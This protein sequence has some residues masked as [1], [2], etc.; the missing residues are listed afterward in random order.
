M[1][2]MPPKSGKGFHS[3]AAPAKDMLFKL[4]NMEFSIMR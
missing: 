1:S 2:A 3:I 4:R